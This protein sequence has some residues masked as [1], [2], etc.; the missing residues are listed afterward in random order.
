MKHLEELDSI[1]HLIPDFVLE[2]VYQRIIDWF[3]L[4][5]EADDPYVKRQVNFAKKFI[6]EDKKDQVAN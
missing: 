6:R 1:A 2:D 3:E 4:G 5:G